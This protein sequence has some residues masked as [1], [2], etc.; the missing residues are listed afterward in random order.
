M[1]LDAWRTRRTTA[2]D[3]VGN[4]CASPAC[5]RSPRLHG[6]AGEAVCAS[7]PPAFPTLIVIGLAGSAH[8]LIVLSV[9]GAPAGEW[10]DDG[11]PIFQGAE[12]DGPD[13]GEIGRPG[14]P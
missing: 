12:I 4:W 7:A 6:M 3:R 13:L 2:S 11:W 8:A 14:L 9:D 10:E 5:R 1:T